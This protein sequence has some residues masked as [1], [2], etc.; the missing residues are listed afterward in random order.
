MQNPDA[1]YAE[2]KLDIAAVTDVLFELSERFLR[3][4]GNF[5]PHAAV[6]TEED[7]V[8]LVAAAPETSNDFVNSTAVL[9]LLHDGLRHQAK[10]LPLKAIGVAENVTVSMEGRTATS[11][12]KVLVEH[13][14]GL[15][16]ALYLP[17]ELRPSLG[18]V[19]GST[20]VVQAKPEINAW[21]EGT[22]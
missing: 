18:Y 8:K 21:V 6:L 7:E 17:F 19:M 20:F 22:H 5:L 15:T 13:E 11:A 10:E 14:R 4:L 12:I 16:I 1:L 3:E 2:L 9:P